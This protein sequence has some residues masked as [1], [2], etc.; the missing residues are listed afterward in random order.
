[1]NQIFPESVAF[2][3]LGE[4]THLSQINLV[5]TPEAIQNMLEILCIARNIESYSD[6]GDQMMNFR[7]L[8]LLGKL[9]KM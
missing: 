6:N 3:A 7:L 2:I 4:L 8:K 1:M 9:S 5:M